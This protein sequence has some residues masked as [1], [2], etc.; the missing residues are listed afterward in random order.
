MDFCTSLVSSDSASGV[1]RSSKAA[2]SISSKVA[3]PAVQP[4][5]ASCVD[6]SHSSVKCFM[7]RAHSASKIGRTSAG[8]SSSMD[9]LATM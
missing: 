1:S 2:V 3:P 9:A 8:R 7:Q 4:S 5:I 6:W